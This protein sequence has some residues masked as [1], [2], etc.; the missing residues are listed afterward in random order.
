MVRY[1]D[2]WQVEAVGDYE[3]TRCRVQLGDSTAILQIIGPAARKTWK[4]LV[5]GSYIYGEGRISHYAGPNSNWLLSINAAHINVIFPKQ[6][7]AVTYPD[8]DSD[9]T[10]CSFSGSGIFKRFWQTQGESGNWYASC[11]AR[12][13]GLTGGNRFS[14]SV[15]VPQ[16]K[17]S[18]VDS[19]FIQPGHRIFAS[20]YLAVASAPL[21]QVALV[22]GDIQSITQKATIHLPDVVPAASEDYLPCI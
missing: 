2:K 7:A 17:L 3:M 5:R 12:V 4:Y 1:I 16:S 19:G 9:K 18:W 22:Y 8:R 11:T 20:G 14:F 15:R 21:S 10:W 13:P 6:V